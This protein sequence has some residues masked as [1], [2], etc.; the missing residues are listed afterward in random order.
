MAYKVP[1]GNTD[2]YVARRKYLRNH[3]DDMLG[4]ILF[5]LAVAFILGLLSAL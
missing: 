5:F 3:G 4:A 1:L 2:K